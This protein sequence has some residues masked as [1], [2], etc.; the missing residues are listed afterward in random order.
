[1][2]DLS[3]QSIR[4]ALAACETGPFG[5]RLEVYPQIGSTSDAARRLAGQ[6]APE[7]TI[8]LADEQTAGRGRMGRRWFAPPG[9]SLMF[10]TVFRPALPP[11]RLYRLVMACGLAAAEGCESTA[12]V[13]VEVKWPNDLQIGGK[14]LAGI[15]PESS[16]LGERVE[17]AILGIGINVSQ[18]FSTDPELSQ[19]AISLREA[20]PSTQ[21]IDRAVLL[22][23]IL[24]RLNG[25]YG[26]LDDA[27]LLDAWR[28]RCVTLGRQVRVELSGSVLEGVAEEIDLTGALW[29][30]TG[31]GERRR[32]TISEAHILGE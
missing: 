25:W 31:A 3:A 26:R 27:A 14:K 16:L 4:E 6:G 9:S 7:G 24:E 19:T 29:L 2:S 5:A 15:L 13:H 12:A 23:R 10:T 17:W 18:D 30:R 21:P 8:V 32:L 11:D 20:A 1:M 22:G 28:G